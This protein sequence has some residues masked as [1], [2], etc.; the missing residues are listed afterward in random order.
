MTNPSTDSPLSA[1][2]DMIRDI[3]LRHTRAIEVYGVDVHY[4]QPER[5]EA[6]NQPW[7][8][9]A[10]RLLATL[11]AARAAHPESRPD[12]REGRIAA[13]ERALNDGAIGAMRYA[14][15]RLAA[16]EGERKTAN[17][18]WADADKLEAILL[19]E[20]EPFMDELGRRSR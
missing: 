7:P 10:A 5:C 16:I 19:A 3:E 18:L 13:L 12:P 14:A 20:P 17:D 11:D 9:D 8:C 1:E 15:R 4:L 6:D 2:R